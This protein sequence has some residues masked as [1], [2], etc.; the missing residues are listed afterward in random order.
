MS[1]LKLSEFTQKIIDDFRT[2]FGEIEVPTETMKEICG[3]AKA[4]KIVAMTDGQ[5]LQYTLATSIS[6]CAAANRTIED[7]Q[8]FIN[9]FLAAPRSVRRGH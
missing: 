1:R 6:N 3:V 9:A 5:L 4:T 2:E 8:K 7:K